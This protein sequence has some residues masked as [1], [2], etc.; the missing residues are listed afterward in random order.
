MSKNANP[1]ELRTRVRFVG[2]VR[3]QD[4]DGFY[5]DAEGTVLE[6]IVGV[7]ARLI[8][9]EAAFR[10]KKSEIEELKTELKKQIG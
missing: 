2:I 9:N 3:I 8:A 7:S 4:E 6:T 5:Q 10:F 1:G